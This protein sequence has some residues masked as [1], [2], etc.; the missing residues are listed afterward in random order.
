MKAASPLALWQL[1]L[2]AFIQRVILLVAKGPS[3]TLAHVHSW[4]RHHGWQ[5]NPLLVHV[6]VRRLLFDF[7]LALILS[8]L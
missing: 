2:L 5:L 1:L 6:L 8:L 4:L 3:A 7:L